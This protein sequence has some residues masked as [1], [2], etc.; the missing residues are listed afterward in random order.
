M[1]TFCTDM[2]IFYLKHV[3]TVYQTYTR[4]VMKGQ[5]VSIPSAL[6]SLCVNRQI[7]S[8]YNIVTFFRPPG[9][10]CGRIVA[11]LTSGQLIFAPRG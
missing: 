10:H 2:K 4:Q 11:A 1:N 3:Y 5:S 8:T 6:L 7:I 9:K